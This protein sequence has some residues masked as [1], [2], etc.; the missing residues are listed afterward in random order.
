MDSY[1]QKMFHSKFAHNNIFIFQYIWLHSN[2]F[3]SD[4]NT[5]HILLCKLFLLNKF[6]IF[7]KDFHSKYNLLGNYSF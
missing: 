3:H 7:H 6:H 5:V 1:I 2:M 4:I